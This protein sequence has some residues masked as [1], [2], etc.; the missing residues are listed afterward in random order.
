[1]RLLG[2]MIGLAAATLASVAHAV[3][4][5]NLVCDGTRVITEPGVTKAT[6]KFHEVYRIDYESNRWCQGSCTSI[7]P[8]IALTNERITLLGGG[9][10]LLAS[11]VAIDRVKGTLEI[12]SRFTSPLDHRTRLYDVNAPCKPQPFTGFTPRPAEDAAKAKF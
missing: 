6:E 11:D 7:T 2:G 10:S 5:V 8:I 4:N 1:M 3:P 12:H 9:G